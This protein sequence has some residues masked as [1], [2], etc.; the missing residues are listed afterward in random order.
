MDQEQELATI[1]KPTDTPEIVSSEEYERRIREII[2]CK[3]DIVYF[4]E[5][6]YRIINLDRGLELIKLYDVQKDFLRFLATNNKVICTSGRQQGKSTIYCIY[7]LWLTC[8]FPEKKVMILANKETTA[9]ELVSRIEMAYSYLPYWLKPAVVL[10]NRGEM[11]FATKSG[12][13]C[14]ASSSDAARGWSANC[15]ILDEFAF[16]PKNIADKLFTSMFPI[17][18]SSQNGKIIIVSTPNGTG[19]LF[20]DIWKLANSTGD[21]NDGWKP[22]TMWWWQVP[23]HDEKW[24]QAQIA[25]IGKERFAQEFN[26][27]FISGSS[28]QKL[29]PDDIIEKFRMRFEKLKKTNPKLVNG[30]ELQIF[31]ENQGKVFPFTMWHEFNPKRTY[32]AAGDVAEG[33]GGNADSS[34]L[35][36]FDITD[37]SKITL[38]AK[39]SS[40]VVTPVEFAYVCNKILALYAH[41]YFICERNG[42]GSSFID[43]MKITYEYPNLVRE[44]KNN[45]Y[46]IRSTNQTK[47]SALLWLKQLFTTKGYDWEI[48]DE[49]LISE[50][51][52]FIK[53]AKT[54]NTTYKAAVGAHDDCIMTLSWFAWM[55]NSEIVEKYFIVA[56]TFR[57][58]LGEILPKIISSQFEYTQNEV[59]EAIEDP[60]YRQYL[61]HKESMVEEYNK[62]M[63]NEENVQKNEFSIFN[64]IKK[65]QQSSMITKYESKSRKIFVINS[66]FDPFYSDED[67]EGPSW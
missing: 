40:N 60:L 42:V 4:A 21:E 11:S 7:T 18:S 9:I 14:F 31:S 64:P 63:A 53:D 22:F 43:T 35:Y 27:E 66:N 34:V 24:K 41:P 5:N 58:E 13:K 55:L 38:C 19:N 20:Y 56:E 45:E 46:G 28:F 62:V 65:Y 10:Y 15:V 6:Y 30:K 44:G 67:F 59:I 49:T 3:R 54:I 47:M 33:L 26:N 50:M 37:L 2:K 61:S 8:F 51:S 17:M 12:V 48:F 36:I 52:T 16:V 29:I 57:T 32:G 39:F 1:K 25:A 23:G